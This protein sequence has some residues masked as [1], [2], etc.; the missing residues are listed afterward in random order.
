[1][2]TN[3]WE[4]SCMS[5]NRW[6]DKWEDIHS[7]KMMCP[8]IYISWLIYENTLLNCFYV[9]IFHKNVYPLPV[10]VMIQKLSQQSDFDTRRKLII[11]VL[12]YPSLGIWDYIFCLILMMINGKKKRT[13]GLYSVLSQKIWYEQLFHFKRPLIHTFN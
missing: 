2:M 10:W 11:P 1:M 5:N 3:N 7:I 8:I 9:G 12:F 6:S 4:K 13:F